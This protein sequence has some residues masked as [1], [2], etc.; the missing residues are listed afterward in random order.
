MSA[1]ELLE[2]LRHSRVATERLSTKS[3]KLQL[4]A[5]ILCVCMPAYIA[6]IHEGSQ[7][8]A[9]SYTNIFYMHLTNVTS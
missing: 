3:W 6:H 9:H 8:H 7:T 4:H 1:C 2:N 5:A